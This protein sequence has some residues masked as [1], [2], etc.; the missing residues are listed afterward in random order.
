MTADVENVLVAVATVG[1]QERA[2]AQEPPA[3]SEWP[4]ILRALDSHRLTGLAALAVESGDLVLDNDQL[5]ELATSDVRSAAGTVAAEAAMLD[6]TDRLDGEGVPFRVL[7]GSAAAQ[8][9]WSIPDRRRHIDTDLLVRGD[10]LARVVAIAERM[11]AS[12]RIPELR[13]GFDHR[14]AKSVT[15]DSSRGG[16][17]LHRSLV[18]GPH[19][20]LVNIDDLWV[21]PRAFR[22]CDH[23]LTGLAAPAALVHYAMHATIT[24]VQRLGNL[25]DLVECARHADLDAA[26]SLARR[27]RATAVVQKACEQVRDRLWFPHDHA[28][29]QWGATLSPTEDESQLAASYGLATRNGAALARASLRYVPGLPDKVRYAYAVMWPSKANRT[30]RKRSASDQASRLR[31]HLR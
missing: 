8:L 25:R 28:L 5:A 21:E 19:C 30:T 18:V 10:D 9:D 2:W 14:F 16:I 22:V 26:A 20:F 6:L 7:K 13:P 3:P 29:V 11:G 12:R 31:G 24:G 17:D 15:M 4:E 23:E 27:W 1:L